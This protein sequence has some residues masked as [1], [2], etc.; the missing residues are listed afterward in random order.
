MYTFSEKPTIEKY[1]IPM[2]E[3]RNTDNQLV[4]YSE[5]IFNIPKQ[6]TLKPSSET[7]IFKES[8]IWGGVI[9]GGEIR[10][11]VIN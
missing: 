9:W 1:G 10:G 5:T 8:V 3:I 4:A 11:G 7:F 6:V 2:F